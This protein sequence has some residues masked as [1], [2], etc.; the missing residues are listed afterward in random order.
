M[1]Q[2][3]IDGRIERV[4]GSV[5]S[6]KAR[7]ARWDAQEAGKA[8]RGRW[9][10]Y[11]ISAAAVVVIVCSIGLTFIVSGPPQRALDANMSGSA[12]SLR[13]EM[14]EDVDAAPME[15]RALE[16]APDGVDVFSAYDFDCD[17]VTTDELP[18]SLNHKR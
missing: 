6:K 9:L 16:P 4:V 7:M 12:E 3:D 14:E 18:D 17:S 8:R 15:L 13:T 2:E 10:A 1:K 11:G 5:A